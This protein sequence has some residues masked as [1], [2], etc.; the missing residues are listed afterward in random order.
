MTW[1]APTAQIRNTHL[2]IAP[3]LVSR[4]LPSGLRMTLRGP[5]ARSS[6]IQWIRT[7]IAS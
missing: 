2:A 6:P 4:V 3:G 7:S 1:D 5:R